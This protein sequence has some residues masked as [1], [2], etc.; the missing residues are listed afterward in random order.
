MWEGEGLEMV[1]SLILQLAELF[2]KEKGTLKGKSYSLKVKD[3][4]FGVRR[5]E[6]ECH[7]FQ[8]LITL[9]K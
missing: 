1:T 5:I 6:F 7:L 3:M 9:G 4:G 8:L 2:A